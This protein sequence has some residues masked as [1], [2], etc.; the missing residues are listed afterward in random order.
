MHG[1][2]GWR[3]LSQ[4]VQLGHRSQNKLWI[5]SYSIFNLWEKTSLM[6]RQRQYIKVW[7]LDVTLFNLFVFYQLGHTLEFITNKSQSL[8]PTLISSLLLLRKGSPQRCRFGNQTRTCSTAS[9]YST[10]WATPR[11][12]YA[13]VEARP[14]LFS[15]LVFYYSL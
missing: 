15:L 7:W 11:P 13:T 1:G 14:C 4:W 12:T 10:I 9:R 2:G 3:G 5:Y 6:K 8:R